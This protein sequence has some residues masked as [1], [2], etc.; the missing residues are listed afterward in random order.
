[1]PTTHF[2]ALAAV[3][4]MLGA[5]GLLVLLVVEVRPAEAT[6][7]GKI[8]KIA[9]SRYDGHDYEIYT[10]YPGGGGRVQL[11]D[12]NTRDE[13]P[14]YS[15]N[16]KKIAYVG[17]ERGH[18]REIY[19]RDATPGGGRFQVTH[20]QMRDADPS[21]SPDGKRIAYTCSDGDREICTVGSGGGGRLQLIRN[22]TLDE[23]PSWSPDGKR[24]AYS[25]FAGSP[26]TP[27]RASDLEIFTIG[28]DGGKRFQ[29]THLNGP[30]ASYVNPD[31]SPDGKKIAYVK[32]QFT[33]GGSECRGIYTSD[34]TGG[35]KS[36]AIK[37][38]FNKG[39]GAWEVSYS[40]NGKKIAYGT[41]WQYKTWWQSGLFT[42]N[43]GGGGRVKVTKGG[44]A[45]SWGSRP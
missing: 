41:Y 20:N 2:G 38:T 42:I 45:P 40:P 10:I 34:A 19:T 29:V 1:V 6:F 36:V 5:V 39:A 31:F 9:Y 12:N 7:P 33:P 27:P 13:T 44:A 8:G 28:A 35:G 26:G 4:G 17:H 25:G 22:K 11:T 18:D 30:W 15:P 14:S 43:V 24:I 16:G 21:W 32:C 23:A 3:V 37:G